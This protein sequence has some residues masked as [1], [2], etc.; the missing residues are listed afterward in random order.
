MYLILRFAAAFFLLTSLH[1]EFASVDLN[2]SGLSSLSDMG[3]KLNKLSDLNLSGLSTLNFTIFKQHTEEDESS[4]RP[5]LN[6]GTKALEKQYPWLYEKMEELLLNQ[7][8]AEAYAADSAYFKTVGDL[9]GDGIAEVYL[10]SQARCGTSICNYRVYQIDVKNKKLREI[11]DS[12]NDAEPTTIGK[13]DTD[14]WK[15][16][17]LMQCWGASGCHCYRFGYDAKSKYYV[18]TEEI[19]CSDENK[20]KSDSSHSLFKEDE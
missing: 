5:Y 11:F 18:L 13:K 9:N 17:S 3:K 14:G 1:A 12:Y 4:L 2:L 10:H 20:S 6:Q 8:N 15:S 16:I 19:A 7:E